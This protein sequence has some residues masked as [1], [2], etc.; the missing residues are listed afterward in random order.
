MS[1]STFANTLGC[2]SDV[3]DPASDWGGLSFQSQNQRKVFRCFVCWLPSYDMHYEKT[4]L[5]VFVVVIPKDGWACAVAP[6]LLLRRAHPSFAL[7]SSFF[8]YDTD[9]SEF[10]SADII[11]YI[12]QKLVSCQK[13]DGCSHAR[14]SFFWYDNE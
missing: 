11:D 2:V 7:R 6:I 5:K 12:L 3:S 14:P 10:D 8:W 1:L 9:F 13:K 4:D